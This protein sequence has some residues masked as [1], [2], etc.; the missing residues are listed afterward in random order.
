LHQRF[1]VLEARINKGEEPAFAEISVGDEAR[2]PVRPTGILE[3]QGVVKR[4]M[5]LQELSR[6]LLTRHL[7]YD[8]RRLSVAF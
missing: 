7:D 5:C 1:F 8:F 4:P 3:V 6:G 2:I